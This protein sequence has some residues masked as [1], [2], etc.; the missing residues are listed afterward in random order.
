MSHS[1]HASLCAGYIPYRLQQGVP[2]DHGKPPPVA[3]I[4]SCHEGLQVRL[5]GNMVWREKHQAG[6]PGVLGAKESIAS[7]Q[8]VTESKNVSHKQ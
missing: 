7:R 3:S 2:V 5:R 6:T 8:L 4:S 1:T